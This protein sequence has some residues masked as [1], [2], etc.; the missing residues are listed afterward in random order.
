[1]LVEALGEPRAALQQRI[2][3][4]A[5]DRKVARGLVHGFG[6]ILANIA[7]PLDQFAARIGKLTGCLDPPPIEAGITH[8]GIEEHQPVRHRNQREHEAEREQ[9]PRIDVGQ[10]IG[11][12]QQTMQH[13]LPDIVAQETAGG[14]SR[15]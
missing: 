1:M 2:V 6:G 14:I 7:K 5:P 9:K 15:K 10:R 3:F 13:L 4:A 12:G 11:R 8:I